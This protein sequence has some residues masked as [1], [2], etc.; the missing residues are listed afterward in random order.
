VDTAV[1]LGFLDDEGIRERG[2]QYDWR[3][4]CHELPRL[5]TYRGQMKE[6]EI[7]VCD[8]IPSDAGLRFEILHTPGKTF[9]FSETIARLR[10]DMKQRRMIRKPLLPHLETF[11]RQIYEETQ[12][13]DR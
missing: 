1:P 13:R 6:V 8:W 9:C 2:V 7:E 4:Q 5:E 10:A 11:R 3:T 12:K